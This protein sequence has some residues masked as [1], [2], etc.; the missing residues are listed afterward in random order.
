MNFL[1][2]VAALLSIAAFVMTHKLL[3]PRPVSSRLLCFGVFSLLALPSVWFAVYYLHILPEHEWLYT[4]RSWSGSEFLVIF[5]GCAAGAAAALLPRRLLGLPLSALLGLAV[6]PHVKPLI[7]PLPDSIFQERSRGD[8]CLQS[9]MSTCGPASVTTIL[10]RLG[11]SANERDIARAT[12]SYSGGTEAWYLA[13]YVRARGLSARFD[14][15]ETFSPDAGLPALVG[16]RLG[17]VGHFI[18]VLD[19][20]G[21]EVTFADPLKG[22]EHLPLAEFLQR[23]RFTGFHM[24]IQR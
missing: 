3:R 21:D 5:A 18:A 22:E 14:F 11:L 20:R 16:V 9:T 13:R 24:V 17:S 6:L 4:L 23:Y 15:R 1:A 7:G 2:A 10:R 19:L 8:I 12:F